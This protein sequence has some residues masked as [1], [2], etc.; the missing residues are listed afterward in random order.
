MVQQKIANMLSETVYTGITNFYII[1]KNL[2]NIKQYKYMLNSVF[3]EKH[4][5]WL[6]FES[7]YAVAAA[8]QKTKKLKKVILVTFIV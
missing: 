3:F 6:L 1:T 8:I 4:I 2:Q 5:F 7:V